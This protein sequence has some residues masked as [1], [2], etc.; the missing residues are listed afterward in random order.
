MK[1]RDFVT[2]LA[3]AFFFTL[4]VSGRI[5]VCLGAVLNFSG[6]LAY[7]KEETIFC[8]YKYVMGDNDTKHDAKKIA[9]IEAKRAC[10]EKIGTLLES[11]T[12]VSSSQLTKDDVRAY[13]L[14]LLKA[15]IV[16]EEVVPS[17]ENTSVLVKVKAQYD[18]NAI[19]AKLQELMSDREKL[20]EYKKAQEQVA[21]LENQVIALQKELSKVKTEGEISQLRQERQAVFQQYKLIE[22]KIEN[23]TTSAI[24][25]IKQGM[26]ENEV[27]QLVG[28]P[29]GRAQCVTKEGLNYG[30]IWVVLEDGVVVGYVPLELWPG[31]CGPYYKQALKRF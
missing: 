23:L 3:S 9:F 7:A 22:A 21:A 8:E 24:E 29:R 25:Q 26:T 16:S 17:G 5:M 2:A 31:L 13:A 27:V 30:K 14:G 20:R 19:T 28:K 10:V 1:R 15:D 4:P 12:V 18:S 11:E 6:G